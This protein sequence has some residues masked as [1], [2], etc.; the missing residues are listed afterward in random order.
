V[1]HEALHNCEKHSGASKVRVSVRQFPEWLVAE[2]E[3]DGRGFRAAGRA[4]R[5][6]RGLGLLGMR[7][8]AGIAG[9]SLAVD[10]APGAGTRIALRV[11]VGASKVNDP[12][13]KEVTA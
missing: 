7:E 3:D 12:I 10:S 9:G 13:A 8:R 4:M 1:V 2:V 5:P 11:P 6:P